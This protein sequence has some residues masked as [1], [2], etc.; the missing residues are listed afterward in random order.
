M[1]SCSTA[2]AILATKGFHKR[3]CMKVLRANG[4]FHPKEKLETLLKQSFK[5]CQF[6]TIDFVLFRKKGQKN[7]PF[8]NDASKTMG[9]KCCIK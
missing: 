4:G 7:A 1:T 3:S 5:I 2:T 9:I 6:N 8:I